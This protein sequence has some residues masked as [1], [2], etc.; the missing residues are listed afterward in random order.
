MGEKARSPREIESGFCSSEA[1]GSCRISSSMSSDANDDCTFRRF[2]AICTP[3]Q[4]QIA[5]IAPHPGTADAVLTF[6]TAPFGDLGLSP[7]ARD[8]IYGKITPLPSQ[9]AI[10][11]ARSSM[12][13]SVT[14]SPP[15]LLARQRSARKVPH[16]V[17]V[18]LTANVSASAGQVPR[19]RGD[20][21][22]R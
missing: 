3:C 13:I 10:N 15:P 5:V 1:I 21:M 16:A 19:F 18:F 11:S 2:V 20:A 8:W 4:A 17:C 22:S 6:R 12:F 9:L 14:F 7:E